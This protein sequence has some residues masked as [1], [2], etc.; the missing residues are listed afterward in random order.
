VL[1]RPPERKATAGDET[2]ISILRVAKVVELPPGKMTYI[3]VANRVLLLAKVEGRFYA[4]DGFCTHEDASLSDGSLEG[5]CVTCP[6]HGSRFEL[7]SGQ[8]QEEPAKEAFI[9][10]G[11][12][13]QQRHLQFCQ[14][15]E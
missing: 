7:E 14:H 2:I 4:V 11:A 1:F 6:L 9:E 3:E 10:P 12:V 5:H 13:F 15:S 8:P